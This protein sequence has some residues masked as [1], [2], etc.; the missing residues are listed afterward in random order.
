M[1]V[2]PTP[3]EPG[4]VDVLGEI[5]KRNLQESVRHLGIVSLSELKYL[6]LKAKALVWPSFSEGFG[7]PLLE[8][9][10]VGCPIIASNRTSIPEVVGDAGLYFN[11]DDSANM[12]ETIYRFYERPEQAH[13]VVSRGR[14][15]SKAFSDARQ[16]QETLEALEEA[17]VAW[18]QDVA[19]SMAILKEPDRQSPL[20]TIILFFKTWSSRRIVT[21]I[22][23]LLEQFG[24]AVEVIFITPR[25]RS[26]HFTKVPSQVKQVNKEANFQATIESAIRQASGAFVFFSQGAS[27]PL[28]SF[29][30]YLAKEV[31]SGRVTEELLY[32]DTYLINRR[33]NK[34]QPTRSYSE[35]ELEFEK[36]YYLSHLAFVVRKEPLY[37]TIRMTK[38][39]I[40]ALRDLAELLFETCHRR[41]LFRAI[42]RTIAHLRPG[43]RPESEI[44]LMRIKNELKY[45]KAVSR[46]LDR[47][48]FKTLTLCLFDSYLNYPRRIRAA[49]RGILRPV[50]AS[51]PSSE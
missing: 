20:L 30:L 47:F 26:S 18:R 21:E 51:T 25:R 14:E 37:G 42:C 27:A 2:G 43:G 34:V 11:P 19:S 22:E 7:I 31:Y 33:L 40:R 12:A 5:R 28:A 45:G 13:E 15:R 29:I 16:A 32:G 4:F 44:M 17:C 6:Y 41:R 9:M 10:T 3:D 39:K 38:S 46:L 23:K 48:P 1:F 35:M 8:A 49:I 36:D 24:Q 50:R